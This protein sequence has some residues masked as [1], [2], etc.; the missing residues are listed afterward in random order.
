MRKKYRYVSA[1]IS[2]LGA[3]LFTQAKSQTCCLAEDC[4]GGGR[5][6]NL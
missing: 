2:F 1:Y 5:K 4:V 6:R 3:A